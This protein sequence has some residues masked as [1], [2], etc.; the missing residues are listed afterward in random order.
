MKPFGVGLLTTATIFSVRPGQLLVGA[1]VQQLEGVGVRQHAKAAA[2]AG[3]FS[4]PLTL[5]MMGAPAPSDSQLAVGLSGG[6]PAR[7]RACKLLGAYSLP[8]A[9]WFFFTTR[10]AVVA[11]NIAV[12]FYFLTKLHQVAP[13]GW[14]SMPRVGSLSSMAVAKP[15]INGS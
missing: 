8:S 14:A 12:T 1:L 15:S 13:L 11:L 2:F 10:A 4:T 5:V 3:V 9:G 6:L 7:H